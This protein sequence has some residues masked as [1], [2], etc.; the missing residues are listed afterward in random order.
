MPVYYSQSPGRNAL[1]IA[2]QRMKPSPTAPQQRFLL[3]PILSKTGNH[4]WAQMRVL[5]QHIHR[6]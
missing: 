3:Q 6:C 1:R 5:I 4:P 2:G